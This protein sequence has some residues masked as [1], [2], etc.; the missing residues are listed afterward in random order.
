MD[1]D[2]GAPAPPDDEY[3][4]PTARELAPEVSEA[5]ARRDAAERAAE[6]AREDAGNVLH[7]AE[8]DVREA[9]A[10]RAPGWSPPD[11][12]PLGTVLTC[13]NLVFTATISHAADDSSMQLNLAHVQRMLR[14]YGAGYNAKKFSSVILKMTEEGEPPDMHDLHT[15][16][17]V[18]LVPSKPAVRKVAV[19]LYHPGK[20]VCTGA[21]SE[22]QAHRRLRAVVALLGT[23]SGGYPDAQLSSVQLRNVVAC[24]QLPFAVNQVLMA[25]RYPLFCTYDPEQF[26]GLFMRHR[27]T[28]PVTIILFQSGC[29][30]VVGA[31]SVEEAQY[32]IDR[33]YPAIVKCRM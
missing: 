2:A 23:M 14:Y 32:A 4:E 12:R 22:D 18:P 17:L 25:K 31:K 28:K 9:V 16:Q 11:P 20:I 1:I 33:M 6:A 26:P 15:Q 7:E 13:H 10:A 19:L 3:A 5:L 8:Q 21:I 27:Y 24:T 30:N 29:A